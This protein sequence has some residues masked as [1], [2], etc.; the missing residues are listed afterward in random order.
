MNAGLASQVQVGIETD[1][2]LHSGN[3]SAL[4]RFTK[5][6]LT[7]VVLGASVI[8]TCA[9]SPPNVSTR[10]RCPKDSGYRIPRIRSL[11]DRSSNKMIS[12]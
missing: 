7:I 1:A 9:E 6:D 2:H 3:I 4:T 12:H 11:L 10:M 5:Q 8:G